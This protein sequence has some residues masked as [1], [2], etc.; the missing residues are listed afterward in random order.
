MV[1][2]N[3][4]VH[5]GIANH[6]ESLLGTYLMA[7]IIHAQVLK[8]ELLLVHGGW[9]KQGGLNALL[10][11]RRSGLAGVAHLLNCFD[12]M[13]RAL[14]LTIADGDIRLD[15]LALIKHIGA[16]IFL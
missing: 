9:S 7:I 14:R 13:A 15:N 3:A 1:F 4:Q 12:L 2:G 8:R 6:G 10:E 11:P 16:G 5:L